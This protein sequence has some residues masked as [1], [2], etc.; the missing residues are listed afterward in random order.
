MTVGEPQAL[1]WAGGPQPQAFLGAE[2]FR[3]VQVQKFANT[4]TCMNTFYFA[5]EST[6]GSALGL[7]TDWAVN[8]VPTWKT[9]I[10]ATMTFI[11]VDA[12]LV[13]PAEDAVA[14]VGLSGAGSIASTMA[15]VVCAGIITWRSAYIGRRRRG[16]TYLAGLNYSAATEYGTGYT[17]GSTAQTRIGNIASAILTRYTLGGNPNAFQLVC[18]S[19]ADKAANPPSTWMNAI[20][21]ITRYSVQPYIATMGSRRSGRGM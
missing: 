15:P 4:I 3:L 17:W 16:R 19:R 6:G 11:E 7:A 1:V 20:V 13:L 10:S 21:P 8:I 9:N 12:Q 18:Y 2:L 5:R 14:A